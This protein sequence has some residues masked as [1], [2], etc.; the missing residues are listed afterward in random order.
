MPFYVDTFLYVMLWM[1]I[2]NVSLIHFVHSESW[3]LNHWKNVQN[4]LI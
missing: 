4:R 2:A 1:P 3:Y